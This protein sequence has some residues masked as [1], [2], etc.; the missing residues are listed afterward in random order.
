MKN[1]PLVSVVVVFHN[2]LP[3]LGEAVESVLQ[4]SHADWELLLVDDGS[5]D[6]SE[7]VAQEFARKDP[8][9]R[10]L[11]HPG[12]T[13]QGISASRNL[14][15]ASARGEYVSQLD[16]DDVMLPYHL[17]WQVAE[18]DARPEAALVY[19]PVQ[20]WYSW[21][22]ESEDVDRDFVARPLDQYDICLEPPTLIPIILQRRYGVPL[23]YMARRTAVQA[24][25]GYENEFTGMYDDQV[26][27]CK[28]GLRYPVYAASECTYRYRRHE[29]SLVWVTN[30]KEQKLLHRRKF[31]AWLEAY[32][33]SEG[34]EDRRVWK[35]L[36]RELWKCKHPRLT[37]HG[38]QLRH[39]MFRVLRRA[40][41]SFG[42]LPFDST[43]ESADIA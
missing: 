23:G 3:Y 36:K 29:D 16:S 40:R 17:E 28:L 34:I 38:E 8:R 42:K 32:L 5:T 39:I 13:N 7:E 41:R 24:V 2:T 11:H 10:C 37:E 31:L 35:P 15:L 21:S 18:L 43:R 27:Y 4:Q 22:G 14:G 25:G 6:G 26:F 33:N 12:R 30:T 9:I 20:R 1:Q 19:G